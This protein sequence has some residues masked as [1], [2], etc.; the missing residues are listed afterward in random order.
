MNEETRAVFAVL[1]D[2]GWSVPNSDV[3]EE[4]ASRG[5][6]LT[7]LQVDRIRDELSE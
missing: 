7:W 5:V 1:E 2:L 6:E 4:L 3:V